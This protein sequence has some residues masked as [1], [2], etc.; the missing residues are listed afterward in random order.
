MIHLLIGAVSAAAVLFLVKL[1]RDRSLSLAWWHWG[2]TVLAVLYAVFVLEV[3]V[4][5]LDEG[6]VMGALVMGTILGFTA[7]V[8][9]VLLGRFVFAPLVPPQQTAGTGTEVMEDV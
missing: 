6:A 2:I 8:W 4:S 9:G 1:S 7:I 5:F 3:I